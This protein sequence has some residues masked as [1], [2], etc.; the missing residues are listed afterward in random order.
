[1]S[2][3]KLN[4]YELSGAWF[5]F[6]FENPELIK[7]IHTAIYFFAI[8][9]CNRLGWKKKFGIPSQMTM[10]AIGVR[11]HQTYIKGFNDIIEWGFFELI[12]KSKNQYST[13]I[14]SLISAL[15]KNGKA[16]GKARAK[17][18][19]KQGQS[20]GQSTGQSKDSIYKQVNNELLN[21]KTIKHTE[22]SSVYNK[23]KETFLQ[24]YRNL[25][26]GEYYFS[27]RDG[28]KIK[29]LIKKIEHAYTT[30]KNPNP[31]DEQITSGF[32]HIL[33]RAAED[34]WIVQNFTLSIIDSQFNKLK[35][36]KNGT[37]NDIVAVALAAID[38][39]LDQ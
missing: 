14:I 35:S 9:H 3:N 10:D 31:T 36:K 27:A 16:L 23:I 37:T 28:S 21:N 11:K 13:N 24:Y 38:S 8:E 5:D 22:T 33:K 34:S 7:P 19:A 6:C 30:N 4:S 32:E 29:S 2:D 18:R 25:S 39:G 15:P 12:E 26:G 17:H 1:M 20:T